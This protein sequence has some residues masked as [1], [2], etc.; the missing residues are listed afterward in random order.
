MSKKA[1]NDL[2]SL[3]KQHAAGRKTTTSWFE[4]LP[5]AEQDQILS[6]LD[7]VIKQ[8]LPII[9]LAE[10]VKEKY[11]LKYT[12]ESVARTITRRRK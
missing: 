10:V 1:N 3:T 8:N 9:C 2:L 6:S 7:Q 5:Q 4:Q 11:K 12:P